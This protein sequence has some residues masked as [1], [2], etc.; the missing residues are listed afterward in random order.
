[1]YP[2][3]RHKAQP[4]WTEARTAEDGYQCFEA[5]GSQISTMLDYQSFFTFVSACKVPLLTKAYARKHRLELQIL[6]RG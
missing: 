6:S 3:M 2:S 5:Q 4:L 1:M